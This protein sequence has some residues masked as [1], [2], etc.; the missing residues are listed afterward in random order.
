[1]IKNGKNYVQRYDVLKLKWTQ[2]RDFVVE[3]ADIWKNMT[4]KLND[5]GG[6]IR[7]VTHWKKVFTE[8]KSHTKRKL[9]HNKSLN[10]MEEKLVKLTGL[11]SSPEKKSGI[12]ESSFHRNLDP[13]VRIKEE[14]ND[15]SFLDPEVTVSSSPK[16][17][18]SKTKNTHLYKKTLDSKATQTSITQNSACAHGSV[19]FS[20]Q[21]DPNMLA[22]LISN[23]ETA[24]GPALQNLAN[25]VNRYC[26]IVER[27]IF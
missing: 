12:S 24:L 10:P 13:S 7:D 26:E 1:M 23:N 3:L 4:L 22:D 27:R 8:W 15:T 16:V 21:V 19:D 11:S 6:P 14:L 18:L 5:C 2:Q 25:A 9:K 17:R 20:S